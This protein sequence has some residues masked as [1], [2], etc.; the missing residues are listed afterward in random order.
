M[1]KCGVPASQYTDRNDLHIRTCI[2]AHTEQTAHVMSTHAV[3]VHTNLLCDCYCTVTATKQGA[4]ELEG[5]CDTDIMIRQQQHQRAE[6]KNKLNYGVP[7]RYYTDPHAPKHTRSDHNS[8]D[9]CMK[10]PHTVVVSTETCY[11]TVVVQWLP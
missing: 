1:L 7:A 9:T 8:H 10:C 11:V 6:Q 2:I 5:R 4:G 3:V